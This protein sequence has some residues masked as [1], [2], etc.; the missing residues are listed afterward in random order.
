MNLTCKEFCRE[1]AGTIHSP[2]HQFLF[3]HAVEYTPP[4]QARPKGIH[5]GRYGLCYQ[6]AT[7]LE[8]QR[9][10]YVEGLAVAHRL[11]IPVDHA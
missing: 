6:T 5:K 9:Y 2:Y 3:D 4:K 11:P 1:I 8:S 7:R 10:I